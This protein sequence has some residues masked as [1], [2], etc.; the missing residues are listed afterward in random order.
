M[1]LQKTVLIVGA[2]SVLG[3]EIA[4]KFAKNKYNLILTSRD[5]KKL[6]HQK[7]IFLKNFGINCFIYDFDLNDFNKY[8]NFLK[9]LVNFPEIII[10]CSGV[11][12]IPKTK[13]EYTK[14]FNVIN[15]N[16]LA[17]ILF[18]ETIVNLIKNSQSKTCLIGISSIS[19]ERGR[20]KNYL[21]GSSKSA[22]TVYLSG[23]RQKLKFKNI[24]VLT[25]ILGPL[26]DP[27]NLKETY[28][29]F[30]SN[31]PSYIAEL[32]YKGYKKNSS[33][34]FPFPWSII[35]FFIRLIPEKIFRKM[36]F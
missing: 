24:N 28:L 26:I 22:L 23:L 36:N 11:Y 4:K 32:I 33:I 13:I 19:G 31:N 6:E 16:F 35:S 30:L 5:K 1:K 20:S 2:T 21:Y 14:F 7:E 15:I 3:K 25:V 18:F 27:N 9:N 34:I 17:P 12:Y 29:S 8:E 10:C